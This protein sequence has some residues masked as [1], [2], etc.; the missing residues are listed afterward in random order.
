MFELLN[1]R[2]DSTSLAELHSLITLSPI[3]SCRIGTLFE[4]A[5]LMFPFP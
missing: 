4:L 3:S 1:P 5:L 2:V